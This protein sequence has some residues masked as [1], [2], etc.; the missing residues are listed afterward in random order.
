MCAALR[1]CPE[2]NELAGAVNADVVLHALGRSRQVPWAVRLPARLLS[3]YDRAPPRM[4]FDADPP[5]VFDSLIVYLGRGLLFA[6]AGKARLADLRAGPQRPFRHSGW[7]G[8]ALWLAVWAAVLL[9]LLW[10]MA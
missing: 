1:N 6:L 8:T 9:P 4:M 10:W 3:I 2:T 5:F 7:L